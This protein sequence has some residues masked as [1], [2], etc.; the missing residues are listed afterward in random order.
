MLVC[1]AGKNKQ[2]LWINHEKVVYVAI[3]N[4]QTCVFVQDGSDSPIIVDEDLSVVVAKIQQ[5]FMGTPK[6]PS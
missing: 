1:F 2:L 3:A 6:I 5:C 4:G